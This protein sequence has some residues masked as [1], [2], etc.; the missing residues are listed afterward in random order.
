MGLIPGSQRP[1]DWEMA[2]NSSILAWKSYGQRSLVGYS[3]WGRKES[4]MTERLH[5]TIHRSLFIYCIH[6]SVYLLI[7][8]WFLKIRDNWLIAM[9]WV[10]TDT[11][12]HELRTTEEKHRT[13]Y[14]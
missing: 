1:L 4:D 12:L 8:K 5:F 14:F 2:A 6:G 9:F 11:Q 3:P 13:H 10:T 7:P